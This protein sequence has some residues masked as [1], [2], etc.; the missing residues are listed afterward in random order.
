MPMYWVVVYSAIPSDPPSRPRPDCLTPPKGSAA[1]NKFYRTFDAWFGNKSA[2]VNGFLE[3]SPE[4]KFADRPEFT[5]E[6]LHRTAMIGTP[7]E[8][9]E[10]IRHY[11]SLGVTEFSLWSDNSLT[12]EEKKRSLELFIEH[13]VPAFQEQ[14][15][16]AA[17]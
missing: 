8:V 14:P 6:S 1:I 12:H 3:P 10:R 7:E 17:Q 4:E 11:E 2:P 16:V 13:V 15:A 5:P 9:I